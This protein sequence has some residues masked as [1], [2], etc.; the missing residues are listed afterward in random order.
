VPLKFKPAACKAL[1]NSILIYST[2]KLLKYW[3]FNLFIHP[4]YKKPKFLHIMEMCVHI[5]EKINKILEWK[6]KPCLSFPK[7]VVFSP[8]ER[9]SGT[10]TLEQRKIHVQ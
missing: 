5:C 9:Y 4:V 1:L 6:C 2:A 3:I 8:Q 7:F 10:A